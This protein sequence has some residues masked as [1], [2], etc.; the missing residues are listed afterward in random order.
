MD[1]YI[2]IVAILFNLAYVILAAQKSI[3]C[4]LMGIIGSALS[5]YLFYNAG[6][7]A[8]SILFSYYIIMGVYGWIQWTK[9][10]SLKEDLLIEE[11][12][13]SWHFKILV[14]GYLASAALF[15]V[16]KNYTDALMP[17]LDSFTTVFSF[18]ATW[19]VARRL[20]E[21]WIYW[22]AIDALTVYL[23]SSRGLNLYAGLSAIYTIMAIYGYLQ[24]SKKNSAQKVLSV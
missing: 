23:Y 18:I 2:E 16:L 5:I 11:K 4:W 17:L 14:L 22:I 19:M 21:N 15:F 6:L 7:Y 3:W 24:W 12:K 20:L 13:L 1:L 9:E 8:E 10:D